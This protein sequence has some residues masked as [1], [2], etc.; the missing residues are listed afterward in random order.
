MSQLKSGARQVT[1]AIR[2]FRGVNENTDGDANIRHGEAAKMLNYRITDGGALQ[3]RPGVDLKIRFPKDYPQVAGVY[4]GNAQGHKVKAVTFHNCPYIAM[5]FDDNTAPRYAY[6]TSAEHDATVFFFNNEMY[7]LTGENY[8]KWTG[9]VREPTFKEVFGY[10]PTVI[11]AANPNGSGTLLEQVNKLN[12][13]RKIVYNADGTSTDYYLPENGAVKIMAVSVDGIEKARTT[14][15]SIHQATVFGKTA[16]ITFTTAPGSGSDNVEIVYEIEPEQRTKAFTAQMQNGKFEVAPEGT[17]IAEIVSVVGSESGSSSHSAVTTLTAD[18]YSLKKNIITIADPKKWNYIT[19]TFRIGSLRGEVVGMKY[20][21]KYN[22][23][24]D[25]RVFLYGDGTNT[26]IYSGIDIN[27]KA[28]AEYFPDLNEMEIGDKSTPI[29]SLIRHRNRLLAFKPHEAYSIYYNAMTLADG[30][31]I[32]GFY[33]SNIN[34]D[35]GCQNMNGAVLVENRVRTIDHGAIYEW[36]SAS[37]YGNIVSEADNADEVSAL[38]RDTLNTKFTLS[39][40]HM[41][42]DQYHKEF[43]CFDEETGLTV[44]QNLNNKAWYIYD[45]MAATAAAMDDDVLYFG[46]NLSALYWLDYEQSDDYENTVTADV[47]RRNIPC[48][49]ESGSLDFDMPNELKYSPTVWISGQPKDKAQITAG[50]KTDTTESI[51]QVLDFSP[52]SEMAKTKRARLKSRKFDYYKLRIETNEAGEH[53]NILS[54]VVKASY[55]IPVK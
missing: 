19:V 17:E 27:G 29:T 30:S 15:Y 46:S 52:A 48:E 53:A 41:V 54:A 51:H 22:G 49:W 14:D 13:R 34:K 8:M 36:K 26:A 12:T 18:D 9:T 40:A 33:V 1:Y 10:T 7:V 24:Q 4:V 38:V 28:T 37:T 11:T 32:P 16:Y 25:T 2:Q 6:G 47:Q 44:V 50:I 20:A 35:V 5:F 31:L 3:V 21:E 45:N 23:S 55:D 43:Y 39:K 42:Y